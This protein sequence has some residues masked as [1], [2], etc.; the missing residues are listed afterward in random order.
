MTRLCQSGPCDTC[1]PGA[2]A[3]F[4]TYGVSPRTPNCDARHSVAFRNMTRLASMPTDK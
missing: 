4:A 1:C 2:V 3:D